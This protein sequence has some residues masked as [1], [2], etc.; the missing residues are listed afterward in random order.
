MELQSRDELLKIFHSYAVPLHKRSSTRTKNIDC[1][2]ETSVITSIE[3]SNKME[4]KHKRIRY[5]TN[6]TVA[7]KR[8]NGNGNSMDLV[9]NGCKRIKLGSSNG[10]TSDNKRGPQELRIDSAVSHKTKRQKI[11]WP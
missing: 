2:M 7:D 4:N 9:T 3:P 5:E 1:P 11:T 8:S 6:A 10:C